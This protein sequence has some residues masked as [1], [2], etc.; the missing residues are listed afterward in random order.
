VPGI[1]EKGMPRYYFHLHNDIETED[2]EGRELD[3][4]DSAREQAIL[5]ARDLMAEEVMRGMIN[6]SHWIEVRDERNE[7]VL[8]VLFRDALEV[9]P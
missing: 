5:G 3:G 4:L 6:L 8:A 1:W 2:E 9:H 7:R